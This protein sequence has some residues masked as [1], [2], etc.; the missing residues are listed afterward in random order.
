MPAPELLSTVTQPNLDVFRL[1]IDLETAMTAGWWQKPQGRAWLQERVP[2]RRAAQPD[3]I[4]QAVAVLASES[5]DYI[6][7]TSLTVDGG[8]TAYSA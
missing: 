1:T 6:T 3:D 8:L 5:G 7:G 4:A 2:M